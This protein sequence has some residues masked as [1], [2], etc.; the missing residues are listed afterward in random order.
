MPSDI[1]KLSLSEKNV[2]LF[3]CSLRGR[4][5]T[6]LFTTVWGRCSK[7]ELKWNRRTSV[8]VVLLAPWLV[9]FL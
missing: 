3:V 1:M 7:T 5:S 8:S 4:Y 9:W 2:C 6:P